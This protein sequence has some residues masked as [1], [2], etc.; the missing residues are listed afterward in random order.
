MVKIAAAQIKVEDDVDINLRKILDYLTNAKKENVDIVCFPETCLASYQ[1]K[2]I[3]VSTQ[4]RQIQKKC[5][6]LSIHCV[7][8]T[9]MSAGKKNRNV[10]YLID[11]KGKIIYEYDK[12]HLWR[13]EKKYVISGKGNKVIDTKLGKIG[14]ITCWDFSRPRYVREL[15]RE[16]ARIIFCPSFLVNSR[17][18]DFLLKWVP[19][20]R[21]F[22]NSVYFVM[23][24]AFLSTTHS[25][26]YIASPNGLEAGIDHKEGMIMTMVDEKNYQMGLFRK[27]LYIPFSLVFNSLLILFRGFLE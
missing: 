22:E 3:D 4:V 2:L 16:G 5:K 1:E 27:I 26:S 10:S 17:R 20:I 18:F 8:G 19:K 24:D 9:Y 15:S 23:C 25:R 12:V 7:F 11:D 6:D 14:I 21:A 13:T